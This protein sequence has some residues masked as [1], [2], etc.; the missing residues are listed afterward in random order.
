MLDTTPLRVLAVYGSDAFTMNMALG[1]VDIVNLKFIK[2]LRKLR[3][4]MVDKKS[5]N[6]YAVSGLGRD[7]AYTL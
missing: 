2:G 7:L 4:I 3:K 1:I 6:I 5:T